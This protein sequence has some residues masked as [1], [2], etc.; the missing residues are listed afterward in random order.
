MYST[1]VFKSNFFPKA[2]T[3][4][5]YPTRMIH[6]WYH[7]KL[8]KNKNCYFSISNRFQEESNSIQSVHQKVNDNVLGH[9]KFI[10]C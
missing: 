3:P 6:A 2:L 1:K 7:A 9:Y 5:I 8:K 4:G 10:L